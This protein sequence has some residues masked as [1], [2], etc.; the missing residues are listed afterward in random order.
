MGWDIF[1]GD[2]G[3]FEGD[4]TITSALF[5]QNEDSSWS[6]QVVI[7]GDDGT[8]DVRKLSLGGKSGFASY[9]GGETIQGPR[10]DSKFHVKSGYQ[11]FITRCLK[12]GGE[13]E[14]RTRSNRLYDGK[15]PLYAAF[16]TGLRFRFEVVNDLTA[17]RKNDETGKWESYMDEDGNV[18]GKPM[19]VP[20]EYLGVKEVGGSNQASL[21]DAADEVK[22]QIAA[23][24]SDTYAEFAQKV[25]ELTDAEGKPMAKNRTVMAKLADQKWF[26]ELKGTRV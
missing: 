13:E 16:W 15:G 14:M 5:V 8:E 10:A 7:E 23:T 11:Q 2:T 3:L 18:V 4:A 26:E 21:M 1:S 9:D 25:M 20:V 12:A 22:L 17:Q 6:A 24:E 19:S